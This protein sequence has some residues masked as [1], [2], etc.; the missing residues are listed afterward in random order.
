MF[1][2]HAI[3]NCNDSVDLNSDACASEIVQCGCYNN[4]T[5][6]EKTCLRGFENNTDTDQP[7][8]PRSLIS[9]IV[10]RFFQGTICILSTSEISIF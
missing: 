6:R 4:W 7:A 10:I 3:K 8:H 9:A 2:V 5:R 1:I